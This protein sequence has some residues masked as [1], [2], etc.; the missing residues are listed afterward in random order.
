MRRPQLCC[1]APT[2]LTATRTL[3]RPVRAPCLRRAHEHDGWPAPWAPPVYA[4]RRAARL[5]Q[6]FPV[7]SLHEL[8]RGKGGQ[9]STR[10]SL[11]KAGGR[12]LWVGLA[13]VVVATSSPLPRPVAVSFALKA[14]KNLVPLSEVWL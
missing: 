7:G 2:R 5:L 14:G 6:S 9:Y 8:Q 4:P 3:S 12:V 10:E 13:A 11:R 1:A